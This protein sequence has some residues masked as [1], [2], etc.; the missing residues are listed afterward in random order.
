MI[1]DKTERILQ[2]FNDCQNFHVVYSQEEKFKIL[3]LNNNNDNKRKSNY[4]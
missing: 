4:F 1:V 3:A 2:H